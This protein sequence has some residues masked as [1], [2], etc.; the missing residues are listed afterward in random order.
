MEEP[1]GPALS[2]GLGTGKPRELESLQL[3]QQWWHQESAGAVLRPF[4]FKKNVM[5]IE[6]VDFG[7]MLDVH[8]SFLSVNMNDQINRKKIPF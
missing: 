6:Y 5:P 2:Q 3:T 1:A 8:K 7:W 4:G